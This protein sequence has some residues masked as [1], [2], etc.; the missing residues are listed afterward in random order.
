MS[1]AAK[2]GFVFTLDAFIALLLVLL[3]IGALIAVVNVPKS[4]L[5]QLEQ[6]QNYARDSAAV[7][8]STKMSSLPAG[9]LYRSFPYLSNRSSPSDL[10]NSALQQVTYLLLNS[11]TLASGLADHLLGSAIPQQFGYSIEVRDLNGTVLGSAVVRDKSPI[12]LRAAASRVLL[13]YYIPYD[14]GSSPF[15]YASA[16][17]GAGMSTYC[18]GGA[19]PCEP[20]G[21]E[22]K[23]G[24]PAGPVI[25]RVLV[26]A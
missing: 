16:S 3:V 22:F 7:L 2:R 8:E 4:A 9:D 26:W 24:V 13:A 20:R 17:L 1:G 6:A 10:D 11:P 5:P 12:R 19:V 18:S 25:F 21:T 15:S 14:A 23:D